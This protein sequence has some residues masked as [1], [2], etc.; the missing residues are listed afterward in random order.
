MGAGSASRGEASWVAGMVGMGMG[1]KCVGEGREGR[2]GGAGMG[3]LLL[4]MLDVP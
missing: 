1:L 2:E 4:E 3:R